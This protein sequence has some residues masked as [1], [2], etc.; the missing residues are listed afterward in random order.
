METNYLQTTAIE[1]YELAL[2][3]AGIGVWDHDL[4][5]DTI[6]FSGNSHM[7]YGLPHGQALP[8]NEVLKKI[9]PA[10]RER[11]L[12]KVKTCL[13]QKGAATYENEYRILSSATDA[14]T[15][16]LRAKGKVYFTGIGTPFRFTGT[17]QDI[18]AEV[19]ARETQQKLLAL[20][21]NSVE[22]MSILENDQTNSYLNKA[23]MEM[24]GFDTAE[25][26]H[27][28]PISQLHAPEDIA[29]VQANVL[30]GVMTEGRWSGV[31]NV[32]HLKT[33]EIFPVYNN[34]VRIHDTVTGEP[35]AIGAVM[36]DMRPEMAAHRALEE[37]EKAFRNLVM[38]APVGICIINTETMV[39]EMANESFL[40]VA[41]KK[42]ETFIGKN[43]LETFPEV[44]SHGFDQMLKTVAQ[45]AEPLFGKEVLVNQNREDHSR[46]IYVDFTFQPLFE[47]NGTVVRVMSVSIDVTAKVLARQKLVQSEEE[48]QQRVAERTEE[49]ER[50]NRE[51][52]EFTYVSSHDL[53]EPIRKIKMFQELIRE[54]EYHK[55][56]QAS[57]ERFNKIGEAVERMSNSLKDLLDYASLNKEDK[58]EAVDLNAVIRNVESDL[59]LLISEKGA[60]I[61]RQQLPEVLAIPHQMQQLFYN[62]LNNSLKFTRKDSLPLIEISLADAAGQQE[63]GLEAIPE[64]HCCICVRDNGIGFSQDKAEKIFVMFQRL[65]TREAYDGT[66]IGLAMCKKVVQNHR[67]QIRAKSEPQKGAAFYFTLPLKK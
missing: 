38:Q 27:R 34:T 13:L 8:A 3:A 47:T 7:L 24:L 33:G 53:K 65:H 46:T 35:I 9:H 21:D 36:R 22:L 12:E 50:K 56:S 32:R 66:G 58:R 6:S 60:V 55:F 26:V 31:M 4:L 29:F 1:R 39:I 19:E 37:S 30:P 10:D 57:R 25:Q 23:G 44:S 40:D 63:A 54:A 64:D 59:E 45:T 15:R 43:I 2:E 16:W 18:T 14:A 41:N 11:T 28:T 52:E 17:I 67:G 5:T 42:G 62:L 48:L 49:L 51:L 20:V 61:N